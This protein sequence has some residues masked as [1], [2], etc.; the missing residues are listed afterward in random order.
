MP[1]PPARRP[2]AAEL[3]ARDL[4]AGED[5][6]RRWVMAGQ[7]LVDDRVV[8]KPSTPVPA[9]A[10]I[11]VRGRQPY[12]GRGGY[13]L[14]AA[15]AAFQLDVRGRVALDCGASTGGF[16]DCLLQR[17]ALLVYAVEAGYGQL[18]GRL[19]ADPRVRNLERTNLGDLRPAALDPRPSV[20]TLDLSYLSLAA[21]LP[22][23]APLLAAEGDVVAL[24]KPLFEVADAAARRTGDVADPALVVAALARALAAG[25]AA[26]LSPRGAVKLAL[27]PRHGV[28]EFVLH[29]ARGADGPAWR[30]DQPALEALAQSP[31]VGEEA[32]PLAGS[33]GPGPLAGSAGPG[34]LAG[35]AGPGPL[36]AFGISPPG[37]GESLGHM[38]G[39]LTG[40]DSAT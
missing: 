2:L 5:E 28:H 22:Q 35:S 18:L 40:P 21:A 33:A 12:A 29:F 36:S 32:G 38:T 13:K 31:G 34:P 37:L 30:D 23:A 17:G 3:V 27:R 7:V 9:G 19:R 25:R 4:F 24:F 8:D 11:R 26:G 1:R 16:T 39:S 10:A 6:A 14:A 20:I 15:L